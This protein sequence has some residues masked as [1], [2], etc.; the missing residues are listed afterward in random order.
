MR[1]N[2]I[3]E[4]FSFARPNNIPLIVPYKKNIMQSTTIKL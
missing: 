4:A 3:S 2:L 1:F